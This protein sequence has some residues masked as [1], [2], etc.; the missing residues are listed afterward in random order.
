MN[1]SEPIPR[2]V[3]KVLDDTPVP[4]FVAAGD[5][6]YV[7]A[8][9]EGLDLVGYELSEL[10]GKRIPDIIAADTRTT[11]DRADFLRERGW[12]TGK[13]DLIHK[14]GHLVSVSISVV[15][16]GVLPGQPGLISFENRVRSPR[17]L[18]AAS[19][20]DELRDGYS[21]NDGYVL[22]N[23]EVRVLLMLAEGLDEDE[24]AV[25]LDM[26]PGSVRAHVESLLGK[27]DTASLTVAC[28]MAIRAG[29]IC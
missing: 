4:A 22:N 6:V 26:S 29:L 27:M 11:D 16:S 20:A 15:R 25:L 19:S 12:T 3:Q 2:A 21:P 14:Q 13:L 1:P 23:E 5:G 24:V 10:S 9:R 8:N 18:M 17:P 7:Y 28:V